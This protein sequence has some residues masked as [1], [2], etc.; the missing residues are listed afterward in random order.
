[1]WPAETAVG[2]AE[3][4]CS[5]V[6]HNLD[7]DTCRERGAVN[8]A[9]IYSTP[10]HFIPHHDV[11]MPP[12]KPMSETAEAFGN[13]LPHPQPHHNADAAATTAAMATTI[14]TTAAA[15]V[16]AVSVAAT[17]RVAAV[18]N[19]TA[20]VAVAGVAESAGV[21]AGTAAQCL[22]QH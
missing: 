16:A 18:V 2:Q 12:H 5:C 11:E 1:M 20:V 21:V 7:H 19:A 14:A 22:P 9:T 4:V 15:G 8:D 3:E 13:V 10:Q 17:A 6:T